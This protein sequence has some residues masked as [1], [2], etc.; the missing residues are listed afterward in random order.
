MNLG[1]G[2]LLHFPNM[3]SAI[4]KED[5]KTAA[6]ECDDPHW[7]AEVGDRATMDAQILLTGEWP[8]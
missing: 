5:W 8:S 2:G 3:I 1:L 7:H 6:A 4:G